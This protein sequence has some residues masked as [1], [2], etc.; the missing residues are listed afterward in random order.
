VK[1]VLD[2]T[3]YVDHLLAQSVKQRLLKIPPS[4]SGPSTS[5]VYTPFDGEV[6]P[7]MVD[8]FIRNHCRHTN[9]YFKHLDEAWLFQQFRPLVNPFQIMLD[10]AKVSEPRASVYENSHT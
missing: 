10:D 2:E 3:K 1:K 8:D 4:C 6:D 7:A 9:E 5:R